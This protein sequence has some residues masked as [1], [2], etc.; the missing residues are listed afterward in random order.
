MEKT[1]GVLTAIAGDAG[2]S[3]YS[4]GSDIICFNFY[5]TSSRN[6]ISVDIVL[7]VAVAMHSE[8]KG[9]I[10]LVRDLVLPAPD[11]SGAG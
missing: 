5:I 10:G 7:I 2:E 6:F 8:M 9:L 1:N 11:S 4:F 3:A